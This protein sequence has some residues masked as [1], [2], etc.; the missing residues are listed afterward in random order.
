MVHLQVRGKNVAEARRSARK[1]Q[2][3]KTA[4][5]ESV[6][7]YSVYNQ[8]HDPIGKHHSKHELT[9]GMAYG[10]I[11]SELQVLEDWIATPPARAEPG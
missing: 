9:D 1:I 2:K 11:I 6:Y 8:S 3:R 7:H 10:S 4:C 5:R